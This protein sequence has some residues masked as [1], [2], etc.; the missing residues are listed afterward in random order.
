MKARALVVAV[1]LIIAAL[2][3][4]FGTSAQR[5]DQPLGLEWIG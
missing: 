5:L 1:F 2:L 3:V 4:T